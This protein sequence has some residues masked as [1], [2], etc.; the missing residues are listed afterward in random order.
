MSNVKLH[1]LPLNSFKKEPKG[2][3]VDL[4]KSSVNDSLAQILPNLARK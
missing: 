2:E 3:Q 1:L 4:R